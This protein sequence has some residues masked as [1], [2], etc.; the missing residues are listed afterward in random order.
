MLD[1]SDTNSS[2]SLKGCRRRSGRNVRKSRLDAD[3]HQRQATLGGPGVGM[4]ELVIAQFHAREF[5]GACPGVLCD[6]LMAV[7]VVATRQEGALEDVDDEPWVDDVEHVVMP[8]SRRALARPAGP[9]ASSAIAEN[10]S[11]AIDRPTPGPEHRRSRRRP[12]G[13]RGPAR[14][15]E[16]GRG[17]TRRRRRDRG[18]RMVLPGKRTAD[19]CY[20]PTRFIRTDGV[21]CEW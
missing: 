16:G 5:V 9:E 10:R 14:P 21:S 1:A 12:S 20:E 8:C 4:G 7:W 3:P 15:D 19:E 17:P 11:S 18:M 6:R 13:R 2:I